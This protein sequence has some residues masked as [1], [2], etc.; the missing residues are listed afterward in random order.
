MIIIGID[1]HPEFQQI[2]CVDTESGEFEERRLQHRDEA[3]RR[4]QRYHSLTTK[5]GSKAKNGLLSSSREEKEEYYWS[6][7]ADDFRTFVVNAD[8]LANEFSANV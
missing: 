8:I 7:L 4:K 5:L 1:F 6:A 2:A 3:A